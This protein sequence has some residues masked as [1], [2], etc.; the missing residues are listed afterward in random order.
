MRTQQTAA[1]LTLSVDQQGGFT[2][3]NSASSSKHE[4]IQEQVTAWLIADNFQ[5]RPL[6]EP[7][8][9]WSVAALIGSVGV[10]IGQAVGRPEKIVINGTMRVADW[11]NARINTL[12]PEE[13]NDF[14]WDLRLRLL[15]FNIDYSVDSPLQEVVITREVFA[16]SLSRSSLLEAARAVRNALLTTVACIMKRSGAPPDSGQTN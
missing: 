14:I 7:N 1:V 9:Y 15:T 12:S 6:P 13:R 4:K 11:Q 8:F 3:T 5:V 16:D 10:G 2:V